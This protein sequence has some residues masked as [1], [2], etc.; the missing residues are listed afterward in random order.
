MRTRKFFSSLTKISKEFEILTTALF[1]VFFVVF[2][3]VG[4]PL[5]YLF[6]SQGR[7]RINAFKK[8]V[9]KICNI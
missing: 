4:V 9:S 7:E 3:G 2:W 6:F 1:F 5:I 8:S